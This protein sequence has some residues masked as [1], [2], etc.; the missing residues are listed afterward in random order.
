M[1]QHFNRHKSEVDLWTPR[2]L[3]RTLE[4][5]HGPFDMDVA[6]SAENALCPMYIDKNRDALS[7]SV[8]WGVNS[9]CNPP[10]DDIGPWVAK[11]VRHAR[12]GGTTVMLLP[13]RTCTKW[14]Q[15]A[16]ENAQAV[17]FISGRLNFG[18][19]HAMEEASA[20]PFPSVVIVIAPG[21]LAFWPKLIDR[22]GS[23]I[24]GKQSLLGDF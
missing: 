7:D 21:S 15:L 14:F 23:P 12:A 19:P 20:S 8:E 6:A 3:F 22:K 1:K 16:F 18:G 9:W 4:L 11:A 2:D 13:S 24:I 17:E 5:R 10:Y